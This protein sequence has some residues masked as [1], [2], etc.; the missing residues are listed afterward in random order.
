MAGSQSERV[1][2]AEE[3]EQVALLTTWPEQRAYA[4]LVLQGKRIERD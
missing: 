1:S 4:E 3:W 2:P